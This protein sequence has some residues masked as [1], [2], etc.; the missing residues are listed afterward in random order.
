MDTAIIAV[1]IILAAMAI[2]GFII[3][4]MVKNNEKE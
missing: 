4:R 2:A 1:L 3:K